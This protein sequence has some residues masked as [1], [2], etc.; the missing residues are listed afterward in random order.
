M[1]YGMLSIFKT[2]SYAL[3]PKEGNDTGSRCA[4]ELTVQGDFGVGGLLHLSC[5]HGQ[6]S[7]LSWVGA[8]KEF[9]NTSFNCSLWLS[10]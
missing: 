6:V 9:S 10:G 1:I 7:V 4:L 2:I 5:W 8:Y 3:T